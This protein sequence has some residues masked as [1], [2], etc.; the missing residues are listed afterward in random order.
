MASGTTP[1][2]GNPVEFMLIL[3]RPEDIGEL[4]YLIVDS[5]DFSFVVWVSVQ[6][7]LTLTQTLAQFRLS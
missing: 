1:I 2:T 6:V 7:G 3:D 5:L 4:I